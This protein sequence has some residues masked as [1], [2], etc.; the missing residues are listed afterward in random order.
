M[1]FPPNTCIP[2]RAKMT[3]KRKRSRSRE[4]MDFTELSKDAT[5]L[6]SDV[7]YLKTHERK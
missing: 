6:F 5:K 4:A 3:M 7:Q 1:N 2:R